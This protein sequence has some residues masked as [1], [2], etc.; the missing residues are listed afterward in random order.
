MMVLV[1][2]SLFAVVIAF[3]AVLIGAL[4]KEART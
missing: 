3:P 4:E 2:L 1:G